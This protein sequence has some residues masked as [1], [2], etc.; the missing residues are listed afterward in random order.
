MKVLVVDDDPDIRGLLLDILLAEA[1]HA[2]AAPDGQ[3]ALAL[4]HEE[5]PD[6]IVLD[7]Q[8]PFLNGPQ[9][10]AAYRRLPGPP[11]PIVLI[12]AASTAQE[13]AVELRADTYLGK[14]F[15]VDDLVRVF[16]RYAA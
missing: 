15:E 5:R 11:A 8:L 16:E 10:V 7:Y 4:V 6:V 1:W 2:V 12:T 9:F 3:T 13:R 14:P